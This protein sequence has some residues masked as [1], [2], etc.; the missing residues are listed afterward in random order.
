[1]ALNLCLNTLSLVATKED[2]S[3]TATTIQVRTTLTLLVNNGKVAQHSPTV[4]TALSQ[5]IVC[6]K[7][8]TKFAQEDLVFKD[9]MGQPLMSSS[10]RLSNVKMTCMSVSTKK[11]HQEIEHSGL[12]QLTHQR[13]FQPITSAILN[14]QEVNLV[15]IINSHTTRW[16]L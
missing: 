13:Q 12:H 15:S 7:H 8:K 5:L 3:R 2:L 14:G 11:L 9:H 16:L 10:R 6:G 4:M 1:M